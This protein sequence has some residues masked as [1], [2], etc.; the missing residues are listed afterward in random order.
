[1]WLQAQSAGQSGNLEGAKQSQNLSI[2]CSVVAIVSTVL[3]FVL[4]I[5]IIIAANA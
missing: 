3:G 4:L 5:I 1:M 2:V